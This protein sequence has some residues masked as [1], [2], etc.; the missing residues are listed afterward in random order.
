MITPI[1]DIYVIYDNK[2]TL[3]GYE[4]DKHKQHFIDNFDKYKEQGY[5]I[6]SYFAPNL[7]DYIVLM[8]A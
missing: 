6:Y 8:K 2:Y 7:I 5:T 1:N 3:K 4:Y